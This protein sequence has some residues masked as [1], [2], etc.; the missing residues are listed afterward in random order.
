MIR[1]LYERAGELHG[2]LC[3]GLAT[4]VR[5]A[6]E[7]RRLLGI[8]TPGRGLYCI[9]ESRACYIDG[10]QA[11]FGA[12]LG[13]GNIEIRPRGK[14]AFNFYDRDTGRSVRLISIADTA[15]MTREAAIDYILTAPFEAVLAQTAARLAPPDA[16]A[17]PRRA[18]GR[19]SRCGEECDQAYLTLVGGAL[20]CPDCA[21]V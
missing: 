17:P 5:A 8:E 1:A 12:T 19:C 15:G 13:N 3:P 2:H 16:A 9:A 10:I 21:Q 18:R 11:V 20:V 7:A 4:G 6:Y 14:A